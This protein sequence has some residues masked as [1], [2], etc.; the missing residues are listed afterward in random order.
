MG[1]VIVSQV[2][3][4]VRIRKDE[5]DPNVC[6]F[7]LAECAKHHWKIIKLNKNQLDT[8]LF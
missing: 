6:A 4:R 8:H 7:C 1:P 2:R 5:R 3:F